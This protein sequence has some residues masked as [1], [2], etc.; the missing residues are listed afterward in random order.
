[1]PSRRLVVVGEGQQSAALRKL[2]GPNIEFTGFLPR[3]DYVKTVASARAMVFA[4]CEDFGIALAEAQASGTPLIAF[5]RGGASDI[6]RRLGTSPAP[7]GV[8]FARQTV[9]AVKQA[10]EEFETHRH[11]IAPEACREN[12]TR[13]SVE[14]FHR[15]IATAFDEV[16]SMHARGERTRSQSN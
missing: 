15:E 7:T 12:A 16:R 14:R 4:G 1:M 5:A 2:A 6:V 9:A 10:I 11:N 8:L 3:R 13:F